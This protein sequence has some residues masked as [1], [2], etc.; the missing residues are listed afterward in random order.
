MD[1]NGQ[2]WIRFIHYQW[3]MNVHEWISF[4][5]IDV[6]NYFGNDVDNN[7]YA[8]SYKL[9]YPKC[10]IRCLLNYLGEWNVICDIFCHNYNSSCQYCRM[11]EMLV[12]FFE[13]NHNQRT[14]IYGYFKAFK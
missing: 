7:F 4:V 9:N 11:K 5:N 2:W 8:P 13:T 1:E 3:K 10:F 6:G 12:S 14:T